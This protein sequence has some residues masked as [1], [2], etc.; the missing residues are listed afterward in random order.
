MSSTYFRERN[1]EEFS[2]RFAIEIEV[3]MLLD[4]YIVFAI[5][6]TRHVF[7]IAITSADALRMQAKNKKNE[8]N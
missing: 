6:N 1:A 7:E 3:K 8:I 2:H 5:N 4:Y